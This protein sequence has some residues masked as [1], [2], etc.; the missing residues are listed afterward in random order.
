MAE[1]KTEGGLD[2]KLR[3]FFRSLA[4]VLGALDSWNAR[5]AINPDGISYLD[6]GDAYLR[7]D[8]SM[9]VNGLWS[10]LYS[11]LLG[12]ALLVAEPDAYREIPL[13]H[14]VNFI[15]YLWALC[16]F[17]FLLRELIAYLRGRQSEPADSERRGLPEWVLLALGYPVFIWASLFLIGLAPV[18]PDMCAAAFVYLASGLLLRIR[19]GGGSRRAFLALGG[20]LGLS[21]LT[22][23]SMLPLALMLLAASAVYAGHLRRAAPRVLLAACAFLLVA[24]V[25]FVPLSITKRRLTFGDS[26]LLNYAWYVNKTTLHIHWQGEPHGSG[27]PAHPTRKIFSE[28]AVYEFRTPDKATYPPWYD[29][30]YWYE[31]VRVGFDPAG[32]LSALRASA[33]VLSARLLTWVQML[34]LA[35]FLLLYLRGC[36][37]LRCAKEIAGQW[38]LIVPACVMLSLFALVH[39]EARYMGALVVLLWLGIFAGLRL[40]ERRTEQ[41]LLAGVTILLCAA[42]LISFIPATAG[43]ARAAFRDLKR[44]EDPRASAQAQVADS[45]RRIG[46]IPGDEVASIGYGFNAL[47]ARL[48]RVRIVAE[49]T[50]G[51]VEA[52]T[53]DVAR[54]WA[55]D[56]SV[57][58]KVYALLAGSG[59]KVIVA[60]RVPGVVAADGWQRLGETDY[61]AYV[62]DGA[63]SP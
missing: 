11:W 38:S 43:A 9:A 44:G 2:S 4:V 23:T 7:G 54:F 59:A 47:W 22:K 63:P 62:F 56:P 55:A 39:M 31:G 45:L 19:R 15:V 33:S 29:P 24:S 49:I 53:G 26:A 6:M 20:A 60:N 36:Q 61:H 3:I 10:P 1:A 27:T 52:P 16:C 34:W 32:L 35:G 12:S 50:S 14:L 37:R 40:P 42:M 41:R 57:R 25:Y 18:T 28:P 30:S 17:E 5:H 13:V 21:Y 51:S 46:V 8:W 58:K 48:A